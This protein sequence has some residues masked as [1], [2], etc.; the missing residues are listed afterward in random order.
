[1]SSHDLSNLTTSLTTSRLRD[2]INDLATSLTTPLTVSPVTTLTHDVTHDAATY[3]PTITTSHDLT[4][5]CDV[6]S[7]I[8]GQMFKNTCN[9]INL[10]NGCMICGMMITIHTFQ[11]KHSM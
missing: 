10:A 6:A 7:A 3:L 9:V 4:T 2:L 8:A 1:M 5:S 11:Y